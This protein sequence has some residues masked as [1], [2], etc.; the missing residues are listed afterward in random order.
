MLLNV[1]HLTTTMIDIT[2]FPSTGIIDIASVGKLRVLPY[3]I[4][5][6]S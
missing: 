4:I 5:D 1:G 2:S 6:V 3:K